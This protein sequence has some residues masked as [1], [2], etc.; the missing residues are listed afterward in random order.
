MASRLGA[1]IEIMIFILSRIRM[2]LYD[3]NSMKDGSFEKD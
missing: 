2:K 1:K 3:S